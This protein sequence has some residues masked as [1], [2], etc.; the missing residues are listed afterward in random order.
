MN[1]ALLVCSVLSDMWNNNELKA[2]VGTSGEGYLH[3]LNLQYFLQAY[4]LY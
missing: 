4:C 2:R 1:K 3:R